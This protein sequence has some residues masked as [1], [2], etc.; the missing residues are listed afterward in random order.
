M[1]GMVEIMIKRNL[2]NRR[3][4]QIDVEISSMYNYFTIINYFI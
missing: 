1:N 3:M 4:A 2:L